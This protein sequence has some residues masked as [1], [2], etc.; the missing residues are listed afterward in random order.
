MVFAILSG[1]ASSRLGRAR[2][3][4]GVAFLLTCSLGAQT[5]PQRTQRPT[6][7]IQSNL[8]VVDVTVRDKKGDLVRDLRREDFTLYEDNALQEIVNFSLED[9]PVAPENLAP[10]AAPAAP[11]VNFSAVPEPERKKDELKDKRLV[12]LFFDLSSLTTEDL[13]RSVTTA[14]EFVTKQSTPH[15]LMA[16]AT[17]SSVLQL[18]QD[19][20]NDREVLVQ[21]LRQLNPS[22]AGDA[23]AEELGDAESSEEIFVPDEVQFNIFNTDRRLS[24][25]ENLA[26]TYREYP[27]R[28]S[29]IYFSS[30]FSTTGIENQS[31][32]RSTVDTA[33]QSNISIYTVDSRGLVALPPGGDASRKAP[34]GRAMFSGSTR[35]RQVA[36]LSNSQETLTT[37]A[38]DTGGT[39]FQDTNDLAPVFDKVLT[40]TQAYYML[41]YFSSNA[42]EDGKFRKIRVE[43]NR[44]GLKLQHRPGYFA[45]KQFTRMTQSE[46][47]RQL[48]EALGLDRPFSDLPFILQADYF[49]DDGT[50]SLVP[51]SIQLAGDGIQFDEKGNQREAQFEFL[52]RLAEPK[53][54][55]AGLARDLVHV[56]LPARS[57]EKI[58]AG[59]ILY[60]TGFQLRPGDY[61]LKFLIRDNRT[62]KLGSFEQRLAVPPL[63]GKTLQLSSIVLGSRLVKPDENS[64]GVS[65]QRPGAGFRLLGA[66]RDPL[67]IEDK[68]IV[69]SIGHVFVNRQTLYV[70]FQ[71]YGAQEDRQAKKPRIETNLLFIQGKTKVLE[72]QPHVVE[73][74]AKNSKDTAAVA[75]AVPLRVLKKGAY[76]VQIH[77]RDCV[78]DTNLFQRV[79][80]VIN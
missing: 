34:S 22:E 70:Y 28:K 3:A 42:K 39:A 57:A 26:K 21:T 2:S 73:G 17:F 19:F 67:L 69:P 47:D 49:K 33:N 66:P 78:S 5:A 24:A 40:D 62:G 9:I 38:H 36:S 23:A 11:A 31:Q 6:F 4:A 60:T 48:E 54:K 1:L 74:W 56:R 15:D 79:P 55:V 10:G 68:K 7:R 20:T 27:E 80:L 50:N 72:S 53:G 8:V 37:L 63:N 61:D 29:L 76:T 32:I 14:E 59:Q 16:V 77:V 46:R 30:G 41:G 65:H 71:V 25:L 12:I 44:P 52:A 51:I 45:S 43:V 64:A 75:M 58:R 35:E 18:I 13:T